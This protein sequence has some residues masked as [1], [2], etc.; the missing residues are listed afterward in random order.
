M[1]KRIT[2]FAAADGTLFTD[3]AACSLY[4]KTTLLAVGVAAALAALGHT[5]SLVLKA[6][7]KD[8]ETAVDLQEFLIGN[9][10][11]LVEA[12]SAVV[13][14]APRKSPTPRVPKEPTADPVTPSPELKQ[15]LE[16]LG[17]TGAVA[18]AGDNLAAAGAKEIP[19]IKIAEEAVAAPVI[20]PGVTDA[21]AG[22]TA[23]A[24]LEALLGGGG[25]GEV[26]L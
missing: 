12:L 9:S 21:A 8:G 19:L 24:E 10:E 7:D 22:T 1:A 20:E 23:E 6:G 26:A 4:E 15:A 18:A 5:G 17:A 2:A 3:P 16:V 11:L 14:K 25:G 13:Q